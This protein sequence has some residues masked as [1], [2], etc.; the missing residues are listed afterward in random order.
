MT[1]SLLNSCLQALTRQQHGVLVQ[2]LPDMVRLSGQRALIDLQVVSLDQNPVSRQQVS[3]RQRSEGLTQSFV[4]FSKQKYGQTS[5]SHPKSHP[6][7][8]CSL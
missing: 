5:L 7:Y 2:R 4:Y 8:I 1:F 3:C 6:F